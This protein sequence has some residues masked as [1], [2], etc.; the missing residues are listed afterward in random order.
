MVSKIN[1]LTHP[2]QISQSRQPAK[3]RGATRKKSKPKGTYSLAKASATLSIIAEK[4]RDETAKNW[5]VKII[6]DGDKE[7][8]I[9]CAKKLSHP[10]ITDAIEVQGI[11]EDKIKRM[12]PTKNPYSKKWL[13]DLRDKIKQSTATINMTLGLFGGEG[14]SHATPYEI[15]VRAKQM[16]LWDS[17]ANKI[18]LTCNEKQITMHDVQ[19]LGKKKKL[20]E[21]YAMTKGL[22]SFAKSTGLS[23]VFLTLT[24]PPRMH[25][26]PDFGEYCWDGTLPNEANCWL[27]KKFGNA[28]ERLRKKNIFLSGLR[29]PD[30]HRDG[31][32]HWHLLVFLPSTSMKQFEIT[33][34]KQK[35]WKT[36]EGCTFIQS[37]GR[38]TAPTIIFKYILKSFGS[39]RNT[40]STQASIDTWCSTWKIRRYQWIG[41]PSIELWRNLRKVKNCPTGS[42]L[43]AA[44]W[45][46]ANNSNACEFIKLAGGLNIQNKQRP[47]SSS[48]SGDNKTKRITFNFKEKSESI[49]F[50]L[51]KWQNQN[52]SR[53]SKNVGVI[54]N[55]PSKGNSL[56]K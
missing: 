37:D 45:K 8:I 41:L 14:Y 30:P 15:S 26:N 39:T 3:P 40:K 56:T 33:L 35:E 25:S 17:S 49:S 5:I 22:D 13:K 42:P 11:T 47:V 4:L 6:S 29:V 44:M 10:K 53:K 2:D 38:A 48:T 9:H 1:E 31:C 23:W 52:M 46:A 19:Q 27:A 12:G 34:R 28:V 18:I 50:Y 32:P 51:A 24:C 55:D 21:I 36:E 54:L 43:L 7:E 20:A 16:E